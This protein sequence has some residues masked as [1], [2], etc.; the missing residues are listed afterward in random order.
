MAGL[1]TVLGL[2]HIWTLQQHLRGQPCGQLTT[3]IAARLQPLGQPGRIQLSATE[4]LQGIARLFHPAAITRHVGPR[5]LIHGIHRAVVQARGQAQAH[6][7]TDQLERLCGAVAS[8]PGNCQQAAAGGVVEVGRGG[9]ADQIDACGPRPSG[10]GQ[11]AL[12][13]RLAEV[14]HAAE[15]IQFEGIDGQPGTVAMS[16]QLAGG[17]SAMLAAMADLALGHQPRPAGGALD[18]VLRLG[19]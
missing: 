18:T 14:A 12:P 2:L 19:G 3:G 9:F 1:Q 11:V 15:Q 13:L 7:G 17:I 8:I 6:T 10:A 4:Q 5:L 16:R